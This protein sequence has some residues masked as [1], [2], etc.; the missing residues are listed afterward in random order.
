MEFSI[1]GFLSSLSVDDL[2]TLFFAI[3]FPLIPLTIWL[4]WDLERRM[5]NGAPPVLSR[6]RH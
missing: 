3:V 6:A 5:R 4:F 2:T 1:S